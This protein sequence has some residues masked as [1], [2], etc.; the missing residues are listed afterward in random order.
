MIGL[1]GINLLEQIKITLVT[2]LKGL[3][4]LLAPVHLDGTLARI[5]SAVKIN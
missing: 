2:A 5:R 1:E 4:G 3:V